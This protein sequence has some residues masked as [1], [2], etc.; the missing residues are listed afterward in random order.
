[1]DIVLENVFVILLGLGV[2]VLLVPY[3]YS[4]T[5]PRKSIFQKPTNHIEIRTWRIK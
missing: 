3:L 1:M 2:G 5:H 4:K